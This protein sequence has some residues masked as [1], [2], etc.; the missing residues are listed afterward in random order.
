MEENPPAGK[1][2]LNNSDRVGFAAV[3]D[4]LATRDPLHADPAEYDRL[5]HAV[6]DTIKQRGVLRSMDDLKG[7]IPDPALDALK[8]AF[9]TSDFGVRGA[10]IVGPQVGTNYRPRPGLPWVFPCWACWFICG[11]V[12]S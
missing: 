6:V 11:S 9:Y 8:Q 3:R 7:V 5:A 12:L 4:A 1:Q 2:D 10:D